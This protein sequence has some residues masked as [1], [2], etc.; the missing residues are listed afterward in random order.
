MQVKLR[1]TVWAISLLLCYPLYSLGQ[2]YLF[3]SKQKEAEFYTLLNKY[4]DE[5][6]QAHVILLLSQILLIPSFIAL[7]AYFKNTKA[8]AYIQLSTVF[9]ILSAFALFGQFTI[10]LCLVDLVHLPQE[11]AYQT[12][13][14]IQNNPVIKPLFY[15]NSRLFILFKYLDLSLLGQ[16]FLGVALVISRKIP[17]WAIVLFGIALLLTQFGI[18]LGPYS[19]RIIKRLSYSLFSISLVPVAVSIFKNKY[20][21]R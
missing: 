17:T 4:P 21:N 10:D 14:A 7:C 3:H 12:L 15:D 9:T 13:D 2:I 18:L 20:Q 11:T 5:W 19:G 16:V 1:N 6:I 8:N